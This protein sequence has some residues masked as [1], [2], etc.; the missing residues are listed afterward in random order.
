MGSRSPASV[1]LNSAWMGKERSSRIAARRVKKDSARATIFWNFVYFPLGF[2]NESPLER[3]TNVESCIKDL[4][5]RLAFETHR[6]G[7]GGTR[8]DGRHVDKA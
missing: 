7:G 2:A 1:I 4:R 8:V 6:T 3:F 5:R